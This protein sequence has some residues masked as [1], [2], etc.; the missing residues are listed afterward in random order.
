MTQIQKK[1]GRRRMKWT[2]ATIRSRIDHH[3]KAKSRKDPIAKSH[4]NMRPLTSDPSPESVVVQFEG[5]ERAHSQRVL[6]SGS[7][8]LGSILTGAAFRRGKDL[9]RRPKPPKDDLPKSTGKDPNCTKTRKSPPKQSLDGHQ[10]DCRREAGDLKR[11]PPR[12]LA[13]CAAIGVR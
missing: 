12:S 10:T 6:L 5:F 8:R 4:Y 11:E 9:A 1:F 3:E 13:Q 2:I 7:H